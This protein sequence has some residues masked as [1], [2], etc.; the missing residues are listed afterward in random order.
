MERLKLFMVSLMLGGIPCWQLQVAKNDEEALLKCF[1]ECKHP[2]DID[3]QS[4]NCKVQEVKIKGYHI[5]ITE[6]KT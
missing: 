1:N 5:E 4:A 3:P 2:Q 6:E